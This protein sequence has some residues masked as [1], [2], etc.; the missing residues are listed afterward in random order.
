MCVSL[1]KYNINQG[2]RTC[3]THKLTPVEFYFHVTSRNKLS[4]D[5]HI[6]LCPQCVCVN[7]QLGGV[8]NEVMVTVFFLQE[9]QVFL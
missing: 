5:V 1:T 2:H 7:A 8:Y 3:Y 4:S 6:Y 9:T